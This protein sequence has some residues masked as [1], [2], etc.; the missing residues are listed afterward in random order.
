MSAAQTASSLRILLVE[1]SGHDAAAIRRAF[2]KRDLPWTLVHA[3]RAEDALEQLRKDSASID[4]VLADYTLPGMSGLDLLKALI[5]LGTPPALVL[6]TGTGS[7][8][9]AVEAIQAGV[10]DYLVKDRGLA[11]LDILPAALPEVVRRH[12]DRVARQRAE[13]ALRDSERRL[14][15][16]VDFLPDATF[17]I[18]REGRVTLWN[19]Q[20]EQFTGVKAADMVGKGDHEHALPF[21]GVRRPIL[22]DLVLSPCEEVERQYPYFKREQGR[23]MGE[24]CVR[25]GAGGEAHLLGIAGPLHDS[26]GRLVGA[27]ESVRD[28]TERKRMEQELLKAQK[29]ESLGVLAGGIAHDFNNLLTAIVGNIS[30]AKLTA[31]PGDQEMREH[32]D[33]AQRASLEAKTLT[34]RLLTFARGGAPMRRVVP[35]PDLARSTVALALSGARAVCEFD[36]AE[37]LWPVEA[38][39]GQLRQALGNLVANADQAMPDSGRI[40]VRIRNRVVTEGDALPLPRTDYV[41]I[42]ITDEGAGIAEELLPRIFDPYFTTKDQGRGLGL[43]TAHS[44]V[45]A[46][47]GHIAVSSR[48][49]QGST[50]SIYL[51]ASRSRSP[52]ST[53]EE[54]RVIPGR[55]RI[56]VLD[57]DPL[58]RRTAEAMLRSLGYEVHSVGGG[59][60]AI[61]VFRRAQE[62]GEPFDTAILDLTVPGGLGGKDVVKELLEAEPELPVL[63]SSGYSSDPVMCA[64]REHGFTG[65]LA[66]P[67]T[68]AELSERV[69]SALAGRGGSPPLH[70]PVVQIGPQ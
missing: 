3:S 54:P 58:V 46:H 18:D 8:R 38:D 4:L 42:A 28:I 24:H 47:G 1:D 29:L 55:G 49:G 35:L 14:A 33:S 40:A 23:V 51:P 52:G 70:D 69:R 43:A 13:E 15:Q 6:L 17:A 53:P 41:E 9:V 31:R 21:Y 32:L 56:L 44:I 63:A 7:E 5:A 62:R 10:D 30:L 67:Y 16:I 22:V 50:F 34:Q 65:V 19:R 48:S 25:R 2:Q 11:Y 26:A 27:I 12:G 68:M 36:I 37:D 39:E 20:A 57:D 45:K 59:A 64:F 60:E 61:E 66:K